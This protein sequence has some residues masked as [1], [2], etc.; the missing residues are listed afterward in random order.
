MELTYSNVV[1]NPTIA[2]Q[3]FAFQAPPN[4]AVEDSTD[5]IVKGLNQAIQV[6]AMQKRA[7]ANQQDGPII[8]E[9]IRIPDATKTEPTP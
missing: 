5:L 9:P 2:P 8:D 4:A 6:S 1:I 3:E 7:Q